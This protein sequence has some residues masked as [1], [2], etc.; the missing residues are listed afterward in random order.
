LG[1]RD[2]RNDQSQDGGG[3]Q[4]FHDGGVRE[5]STGGAGQHP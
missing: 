5:S 2:A 3:E 4:F 1:R